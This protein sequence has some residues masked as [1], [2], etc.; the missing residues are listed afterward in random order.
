MNPD[1]YSSQILPPDLDA[2]TPL[3]LWNLS[4]WL[5][6]NWNGDW[7]TSV[8]TDELHWTLCG[9]HNLGLLERSVELGI[10]ISVEVCDELATVHL[11]DK[12]HGVSLPRMT[13]ERA[14]RA[15]CSSLSTHRLT[16]KWST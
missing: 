12:V 7:L 1:K 16:M 11:G 15:A 3:T 5:L 9:A 10:V 6:L 2:P 14:Q 13:F 8:Y 4:L